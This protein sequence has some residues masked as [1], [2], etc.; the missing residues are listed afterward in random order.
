MATVTET[1]TTVELR[2]SLTSADIATRLLNGTLHAGY[3]AIER[4]MTI[5]GL[6]K[7]HAAEPD[8][9][10]RP[11]ICYPIRGAADFEEHTAGD[12]DR[13]TN[14]AVRYY[15][16]NGLQPAVRM[17]H[18]RSSSSAKKLYRTR[19]LSKRLWLL[20]LQDLA[21]RLS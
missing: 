2:S 14:V 21:S 8:E 15:M 9:A 7:S 20:S 18:P 11:L 3:P 12:L 6:L 17:K 5:D 13:Y 10:K 4:F 16:E 1:A 19:T